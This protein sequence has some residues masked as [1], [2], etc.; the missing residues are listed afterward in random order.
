MMTARIFSADKKSNNYTRI[1][2]YFRYDNCKKV[3]ARMM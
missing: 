1:V 2:F 3:A